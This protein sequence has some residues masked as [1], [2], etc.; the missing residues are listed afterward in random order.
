MLTE[1]YIEAV[2]EGANVSAAGPE[3]SIGSASVGAQ[4]SRL[5]WLLWLQLALLLIIIAF[6]VMHVRRTAN[7]N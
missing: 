2:D 4:I 1:I 7:R 6:L 5:T 3:L